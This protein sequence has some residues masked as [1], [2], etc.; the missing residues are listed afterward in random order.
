MSIAEV[1]N[2]LHKLVV[3]TDNPEILTEVE[4]Y[5]EE[6]LQQSDWW[7]VLSEKE[8]MLIEQGQSQLDKG[9]GI[10]NESVQAAAKQLL[11]NGSKE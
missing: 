9:E 1:K 8:K 7:E 4:S 5:F 3:E 2:K 6:L 11:Q 10:P